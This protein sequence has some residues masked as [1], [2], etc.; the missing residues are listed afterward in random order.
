MPNPKR[1]V[2]NSKSIFVK[3]EASPMNSNY[4]LSVNIRLYLANIIGSEYKEMILL[5]SS[6]ASSSYE[7][8]VNAVFLRLCHHMMITQSEF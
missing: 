1:D 8:N 3:R 6:S 5:K 2:H 7:F 4:L